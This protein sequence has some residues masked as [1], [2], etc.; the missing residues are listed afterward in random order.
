MALSSETSKQIFVCT[1]GTVYTVPFYFLQNADLTVYRQDAAGNTSTLVLTTDYTLTGA[2][3]ESGGELTTVETFSDG[4][5]VVVRNVAYTQGLDLIAGDG[6]RPDTLEKELDRIVMQVQQLAR[7]VGVSL[8]LPDS[9]TSGASAELPSPEAG[10][11]LAWNAT[12]DAIVNEV[13]Q[14]T[15]VG[16]GSITEPKLADGAVTVEKMADGAVTL[17]KIDADATSA[18]KGLMRFATDAETIT[19][20]ETLAATTPANIRA[21]YDRLFKGYHEGLIISNNA[22]DPAYDID[23]STGICRDSGN[24]AFI[25]LAST[26]TKRIDAA[27][28]TGTDAGGLPSGLTLTAG[29]FYRVFVLRNPTT[30]AV[31]AGFDTSATATNLL[32]AATGYTQYRQVGWVKTNSTP[33]IIKMGHVDGGFYRWYVPARD[34]SETSFSSSA[35]LKALSAPPGT[36]AEVNIYIS[37]MTGSTTF[38]GLFTET[39]QTDTAPTATESDIKMVQNANAVHMDSLIITRKV[40]ASSQI[41]IRGSGTTPQYELRTI[42]YK[43]L[44]D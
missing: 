15:V 28:A 29:T 16:N 23:V 13:P 18:V 2:G 22:I 36:V 37:L 39:W 10:K 44:W 42:G 30:G 25:S 35:V 20:T 38:Y 34:H 21:A 3:E 14:Y 26:I 4:K 7:K 11:V 19:G 27:W 31:D 17:D 43:Y 33:T 40:D 1:G 9:D 12:G 5:L 8:H 32:T 41:R 6:F 24:V